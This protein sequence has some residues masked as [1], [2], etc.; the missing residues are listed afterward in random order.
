MQKPPEPTP[1]H[2]PADERAR[3]PGALS[4]ATIRSTIVDLVAGYTAEEGDKY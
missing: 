2:P 3:T 4:D 1:S